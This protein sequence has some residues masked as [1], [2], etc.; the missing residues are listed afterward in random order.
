M[1]PPCQY[2]LNK[3]PLTG[4]YVDHRPVVNGFCLLLWLLMLILWLVA[5]SSVCG[6]I[7]VRQVVV[8]DVRKQLLTIRSEQ[9][10]SG[11]VCR[12]LE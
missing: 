7:D 11:I 1:R 10:E 6:L 2:G 4:E 12:E 8:S 9:E 5:L 3:R